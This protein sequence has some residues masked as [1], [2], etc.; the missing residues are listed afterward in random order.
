MTVEFFRTN[1]F[2]FI[3][4][5]QTEPL[6]NMKTNRVRQHL[7]RE[8]MTGK[9]FK[10]KYLHILF[11]FVVVFSQYRLDAAMEENTERV[12]ITPD[13]HRISVENNNGKQL[14][15]CSDEKGLV[16]R[17]K[18]F[19]KAITCNKIKNS[20][21]QFKFCRKSTN[22]KFLRTAGSTNSQDQYPQ[23][24][25]PNLRATSAVSSSI[26][27]TCRKTCWNCPNSN[28]KCED[29]ESFFWVS[30]R[31][32]R[33]CAY[34]GVN[35]KRRKKCNKKVYKGK[36]ISDICCQSCKPVLTGT[37]T[38]GAPTN[39]P[40]A[41]P[42]LTRTPTK[43]KPKT[44]APSNAKPTTRAP[45]NAEPTV[46]TA[47]P[48][49]DCPANPPVELTPVTDQNLRSA[50][51][52]WIGNLCNALLKYGEIRAWE[53][54]EVTD[55]K[56]IFRRQKIFNENLG[57]WQTSKV[58][59]MQG[60]F[61]IAKKFNGDITDWDT[62]AVKEIQFMFNNAKAFNQD[63][64][65]WDLTSCQDMTSMFEGAKAFNSKMKKMTLTLTNMKDIF[66]D[67]PKFKSDLDWQMP[68]VKEMTGIFDGALNFKGDVSSWGT[69]SVIVM[70]EIFRGTKLF[71]GDLSSWDTT[72]VT[73]MLGIFKETEKFNG[74]IGTWDTSNVIDMTSLFY[75][76]LSFNA[77][78]SSWDISRVLKV[79]RMFSSARVFNV[80]ITKW[81]L[82]KVTSMKG[83]F[84]LEGY[85]R[86]EAHP[87][88]AF[89]QD[90]GSW[91]MS[92]KKSLHYMV[93]GL[94]VFDQDLNSWDVSGVYDLAGLFSDC[95]KFNSN[96]SNWDVSGNG[97][98]SMIFYCAFSFNSDISSWDTSNA[99]H[100]N[101]VFK[102][103]CS[104]DL[105]YIES[106]VVDPNTGKD[107]CWNDPEFLF[108]QCDLCPGYPE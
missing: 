29:D 76:A 15:V 89:N 84:G 50:V 48:T 101:N 10:F 27:S 24:P 12:G 8:V 71:N 11:L 47:R 43:V 35:R 91:D 96:L 88:S 79:D 6:S 63:L 59:N 40:S 42:V 37:P 1:T 19:G 105:S 98:L 46:L 81:N 20:E 52:L 86:G 57:L 7:S 68:N 73:A 75:K 85:S 36:R 107:T 100:W 17:W 61:T 18:K 95:R 2:K 13:H 4:W 44:R 26:A 53:T 64:S 14:S 56:E 39:T 69:K 83:F 23:C 103:A 65:S 31:L 54:S 28:D 102:G 9:K 38:T 62:S 93:A 66:K 99:V 3:R 80:D 104:F 5:N 82:S 72:S 21:W 108:C 30:K 90:L 16:Y 25:G 49:R 74:R 22:V 97:K 33:N 55:M 78:M 60:V 51:S 41:R 106:W 92:N 87:F 77:D 67:A 45:T 34:F 58:T 32:G 70:N 94:H